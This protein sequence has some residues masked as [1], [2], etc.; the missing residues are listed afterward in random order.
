MSMGGGGARH[1]IE[2]EKEK[3]GKKSWNEVK[4]ITAVKG[5]VGMHCE[6]H[7][8]KVDRYQL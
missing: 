6:G 1:I 7:L 5:R 8:F 3:V 2:K 4:I